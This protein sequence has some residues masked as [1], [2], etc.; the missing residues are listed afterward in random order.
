VHTIRR[1][2]VEG[3]ERF[4]GR[5]D[6][7]AL[8]GGPP[9]DPGLIGPGSVSWEINADIASVSTA[10]TAAIVL[11]ILHPSVIAGV[12]DRSTYREDPFRRARTTLGYV[13]GT[14]FGNTEAAT[15]LIARVR[16]IHGRIEGT[17][18]DGTPYRAL[19]PVL[20]A[21]VHTTI[22]WMI[23]RAFERYRR[24]LSP[25]ERDRYLAEQAVIGR[26]GGAEAVPET[27][28][29]LHDYVE[30]MRPQLA[31]NA[32]TREFFA[33]LMTAPFLPR[34]PAPV[35]RALHRFVVHAGMSL[36]PAWARELTGFDHPALVQRTL[37]EPY[38]QLDARM[39]RWAFGTPA[40]VTLARERAGGVAAAG[41]VGTAG[42]AGAGRR[43][44]RAPTS[45]AGLAG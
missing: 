27:T 25:R 22:P 41:A 15:E 16:R 3:F 28:A 35:D 2:I 9:G 18:P 37:V 31:V 43:A 38:L 4:S 33:F 40:H 44:S 42:N 17:R 26:M 29:E 24:P 11:E 1:R 36:A 19:D 20:L 32:Q 39:L 10:G 30:A 34:T 14:T 23:M 13:L 12:Q 7:P 21:W 45:V 5:H 6:D 8:Y